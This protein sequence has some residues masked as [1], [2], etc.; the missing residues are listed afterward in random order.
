[1][2]AIFGA[3]KSY[4]DDPIR[5][6]KAAIEIRDV[7]NKI[8]PE[9]EDKIG[10]P[11]SMH[12]GI[13]TGLVVTGE[14]DLEKG[15]HGTVGDTINRAARLSS[16]SKANEIFVGFETHSQ[17]IGYFD[18]ETLEP[19]KVKGKAKSIRVYKGTR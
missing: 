8:S 1:V 19:A 12:S 3:T 5:A 2:V 15:T 14:V 4:E 18:F 10:H 16:L 6:I 13:N 17:T 7:A 9:Y 11:I